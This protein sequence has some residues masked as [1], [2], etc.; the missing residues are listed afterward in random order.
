MSLLRTGCDGLQG[1]AII[2]HKVAKITMD[3]CMSGLKKEDIVT[4]GELSEISLKHTDLAQ[5]QVENNHKIDIINT[6]LQVISDY[7]DDV[8]GTANNVLTHAD[9]LLMVSL[10]AFSVFSA[11][12]I[13]GISIYFNKS[14]AAYVK[15][16]TDR[17]LND[18]S[19]DEKVRELFI[20]KIV[21]HP[22]IRDNI[23]TAIDRISED[24]T[25]KKLKENMQNMIDD[26]DNSK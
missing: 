17:L 16:A 12:A 25:N 24:A 21:E 1:E 15:E 3:G 26:I 13:L 4:R 9:T 14:K 20:E 5:K 8:I 18:I 19:K 11:L 7:T 2:K 23:N 6:K 22:N 10:S